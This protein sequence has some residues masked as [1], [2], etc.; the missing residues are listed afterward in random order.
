MADTKEDIVRSVFRRGSSIEWKLTKG[1]KPF[2]SFTASSLLTERGLSGC[3]TAF[4]SSVARSLNTGNST[5][6]LCGVDIHEWVFGS[7]DREGGEQHPLRKRGGGPTVH[8]SWLDTNIRTPSPCR[9]NGLITGIWKWLNVT[10]YTNWC[11]TWLTGIR[12]DLLP[13][14]LHVLCSHHRS[15]FQ[16]GLVYHEI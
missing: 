16:W 14:N 6:Q 2:S 5:E 10:Q 1:R 7:E 9:G 8:G 4:C 3:K 12:S 13:Q 15:G 11:L